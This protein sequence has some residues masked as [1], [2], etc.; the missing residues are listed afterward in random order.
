L[1]PLKA[2]L[3][4]VRR[5]EQELVVPFSVW[6]HGDFNSNNVLYSPETG[7]Q[8]IDVARSG[9]GDYVQDVSVFLV[10]N[11]RRPVAPAQAQEMAEVNR[12]FVDLV[13]EFATEQQDQ[14]FE[15][16]LKLGLA[17]SFLTSSRL[18]PD[19]VWAEHLFRQGW[20]LLDQVRRELASG[21]AG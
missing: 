12:C 18:W 16:R 13:R 4:E 9:P 21:A 2:C 10:S 8:F 6:I 15:L 17:R 19:P 1:P 11:Q 3:E 20:Q 14:S 7:F 5:R